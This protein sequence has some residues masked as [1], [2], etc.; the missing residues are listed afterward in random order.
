MSQRNGDD[1][2][3]I[4]FASRHQRRQRLGQLPVNSAFQFA[5]AI[6]FTETTFQKKLSGF[7]QNFDRETPGAKARVD[8]ALQHLDV[9]VENRFDRF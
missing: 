5:R 2:P 7:G 3:G 9:I 1:R 8:V 6:L 4:D